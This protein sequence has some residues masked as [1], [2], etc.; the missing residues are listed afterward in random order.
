M[1]VNV[2]LVGVMLVGVTAVDVTG[3]NAVTIATTMLPT[4]VGGTTQ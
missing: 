2:M 1:V 3:E 4:V